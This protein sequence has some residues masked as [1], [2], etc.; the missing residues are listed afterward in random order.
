MNSEQAGRVAENFAALCNTTVP[1]YE[2]VNKAR[3][4]YLAI[5]VGSINDVY[6]AAIQRLKTN[7]EQTNDFGERI[8]LRETPPA[9]WLLSHETQILQRLISES[10]TVGRSTLQSDFHEKF[11]PFL[12]G[13]EGRIYS[14]ANHVVFDVVAPV[15]PAWSFTRVTRPKRQA[16]P[17]VGSPFNS[18][19]GVPTF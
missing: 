12:G 18:I 19:V 7:S 9:A 5:Q 17:S 3:V 15:S 11:I 10:L 6:A 1:Q 14:K 4:E 16:S 13:E 2:V 8:F